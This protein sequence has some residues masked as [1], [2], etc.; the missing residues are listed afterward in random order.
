[1]SVALGDQMLNFTEWSNSA[2]RTQSRTVEPSRS[3]AK[4]K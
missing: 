3:T 4:L 2:S 1:M